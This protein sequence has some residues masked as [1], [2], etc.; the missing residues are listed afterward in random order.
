MS[1]Y[2]SNQRL[3]RKGVN[4]VQYIEPLAGQLS[5]L[6]EDTAIDIQSN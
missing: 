6:V 2:C 3:R 1:S 5:D 4:G